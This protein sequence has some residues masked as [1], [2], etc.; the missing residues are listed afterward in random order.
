V[1]ADPSECSFQ[2]NPVGIAKFTTSCDI[3]KSAL[4]SRSVNYQNEAAPKGT[5]ASVKVGDTVIQTGTPDFA[6]QLGDAIAK[7]GYPPSADPKEIN[8]FMVVLLLFY[9][10]I[11]VTMVYGPIA[12]MLVELFPTR[13]RYT[14]MSL[15]YHI[16]N[17]WFGGFLPFLAVAM[18]AAKGDI[19]YGLWY[20][21]VIAAVTF[22]VGIF[23]IHETKDHKID[24]W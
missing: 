13:I 17:G 7:H 8:Y 5:K 12:A 10:V 11:L 22:I 1:I 15:P 4:V 18:V 24:V 21:I 23:F 9:L 19:Y 14:S 20:P 16:G 2:F 3:A 6:K